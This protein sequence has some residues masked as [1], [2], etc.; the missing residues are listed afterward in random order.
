EGWIEAGVDGVVVRSSSQVVTVCDRVD[1]P[2]GVPVSR[3][4]SGLDSIEFAPGSTVPAVGPI[5]ERGPARIGRLTAAFEA[6]RRALLVDHPETV[7]AD[8]R[9]IEVLSRLV[10]ARAVLDGGRSR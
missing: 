1:V 4:T 5:A 3:T 6:G 7:P 9:V 2:V 8:R 10:T